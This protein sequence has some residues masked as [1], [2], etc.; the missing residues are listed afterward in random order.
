MAKLF[1]IS[2][3]EPIEIE[4][5]DRTCG[6]L[7]TRL[8]GPGLTIKADGVAMA[9]TAPIPAG[10]KVIELIGAPEAETKESNPLPPN[11]SDGTPAL[12]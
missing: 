4:P 3:G 6:A 11:D 7:A 5:K 9:P 10:V 8:G 2:G 12:L 1:G